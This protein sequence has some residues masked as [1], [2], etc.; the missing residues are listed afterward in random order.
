[1]LGVRFKV[2]LTFV[3]LYKQLVGDW[4]QDQCLL[5]SVPIIMGCVCAIEPHS[6]PPLCASTDDTSPT[7]AGF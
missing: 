5:L 4:K 7:S 6:G 1:M 2:G 3:A